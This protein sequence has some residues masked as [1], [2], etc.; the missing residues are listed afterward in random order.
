[1][2]LN[3]A[4]R[5]AEEVQRKWY[6]YSSIYLFGSQV[7]G[8]ATQRSDID[9]AVV[10]DHI[11]EHLD[12]PTTLF[13]RKGDLIGLADEIDWKIEPHLIQ[14]EYDRSGFLD[15]ILETGIKIAG[16]R[17]PKGSNPRLKPERVTTSLT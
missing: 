2:V 15:N 4:L 12:N 1:M 10:I 17:K 6:P 9:I 5:F 3:S 13:T 11:P 8:T 7:K 14:A 16:P